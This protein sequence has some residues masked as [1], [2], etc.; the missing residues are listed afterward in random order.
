MGCFAAGDGSAGAL[1]RNFDEPLGSII[2]PFRFRGPRFR[3]R[4]GR[5]GLPKGSSG[6]GT[7]KH[8]RL[9]LSLGSKIHPSGLRTQKLRRSTLQLRRLT[10]THRC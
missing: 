2:A 7:E 1:D 6:F 3:F 10:P 4:N 5:L 9:T 8:R